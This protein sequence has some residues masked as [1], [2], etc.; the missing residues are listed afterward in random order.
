MSGGGGVG[1]ISLG[2]SGLS[3]RRN[4]RRAGGG[5]ERRGEELKL[6]EVGDEMKG[7]DGEVILED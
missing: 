6:E 3:G 7:S 4:Q 2:V 1:G 5:E